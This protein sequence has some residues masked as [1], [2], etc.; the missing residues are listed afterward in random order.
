MDA[1]RHIGSV[2]LR[3][4]IFIVKIKMRIHAWRHLPDRLFLRK[5]KTILKR[6]LPRPPR[7]R[8]YCNIDGRSVQCDLFSRYVDEITDIPNAKGAVTGYQPSHNARI[9]TPAL[10]RILCF[11]YDIR[12]GKLSPH[13]GGGQT[14]DP[15]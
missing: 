3:N 2:C 15:G 11:Q 6:P 8:V 9:L 12:E 1:L 14:A 10:S 5:K 7:G 4:D 13:P